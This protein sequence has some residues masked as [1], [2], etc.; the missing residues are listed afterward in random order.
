MRKL[1]GKILI[2][3]YGSKFWKEVINWQALVDY[4][5][6]AESDLDLFRFADD[7]ATAL[8]I[9]EEGLTKYYLEPEEA[10]PKSEEAPEI[11]RSRLS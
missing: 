9:L 4:G 1:E 2:V 6:I 3:L 7:P 11:A 10:L 8:Q 5:M